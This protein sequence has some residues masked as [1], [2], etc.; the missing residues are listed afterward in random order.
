MTSMKALAAQTVTV[1][2]EATIGR[3]IRDLV[4]RALTG[5]PPP[6]SNLPAEIEQVFPGPQPTGAAGGDIAAAAGNSSTSRAPRGAGA[7]ASR[8]P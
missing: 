2:A 8:P 6:A 4:D 1:P 7:A 3:I 5:S